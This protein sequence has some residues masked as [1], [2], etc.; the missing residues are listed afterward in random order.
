MRKL[1]RIK[2][3]SKDKRRKNPVKPVCKIYDK[4]LRIEAVKPINSNFPKQGFYH[5]FKL[6]T[7]A[8]IYGMPDGSLLIKGKK[9]LWKK[10][11]YRKNE[12]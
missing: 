4:V 12:I 7:K 11:R 1:R 2:R 9:P 3:K 10:F 5:N 8:S 6:K